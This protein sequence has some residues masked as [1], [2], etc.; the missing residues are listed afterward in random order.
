[1]D[2]SGGV[3]TALIAA[4]A[5]VLGHVIG[6]WRERRKDKAQANHTEL[7]DLRDECRSLR[8]DLDAVAKEVRTLRVREIAWISHTALQAQII[9]GVP[10]PIPPLP[11]ELRNSE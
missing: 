3:W 10:L 2:G 9:G 1:M 5:V 6:T 4:V 11:P 7:E 8:T